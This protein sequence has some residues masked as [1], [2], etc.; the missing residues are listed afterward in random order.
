MFAH[1]M[2]GA[3]RASYLRLDVQRLRK[4]RDRRRLGGVGGPGSASFA[5]QG[6]LFIGAD[7]GRDGG[8]I[9]RIELRTHPGEPGA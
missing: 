3:P 1:S 4:L 6:N 5:D 2:S 9:S 7:H 8:D